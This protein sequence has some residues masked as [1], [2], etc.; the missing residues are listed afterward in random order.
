MNEDQRRKNKWFFRG[1]TF[2]LRKTMP[3]PP[4]LSKTKTTT[5]NNK[6]QMWHVPREW[7][8]PWWVGA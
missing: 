5:N 4:Q 6:N 2:G 3:F 1:R 7:S 8:L